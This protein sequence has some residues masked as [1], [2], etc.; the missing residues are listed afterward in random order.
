MSVKT[1]MQTLRII[2][3]EEWAKKYYRKSNSEGTV[4]I[5]RTSLNIFDQFCQTEIGLNGKSRD[6]MIESYQKLFNQDKPDIR[7]ICMSLDKFVGFMGEDHD[8][9]VINGRCNTTFKAKKSKTIKIYFGFIKNYLRICHGIRITNEDIHDYVQFPKH[10]KEPR[11]PISLDT[12]KLLFGKCDPERRA[13]YYVLISSGM[14]IGE[15]LSL[16]KS[17]FHIEERPIRVSLLADDTK[18]L[19]ARET[20]ISNEAWERVKPIF[21]RKNDNEYL[22]HVK[23]FPTILKALKNEE[24]YFISLRK[25][26]GLTERYHNSIRAV[27]NIHSFRA[28]FHTKASQKHGSDYANALDG[29]GAYLKQ[30]YRES[31][32]FREAVKIAITPMITSLSILNYVDMD[33]EVEVLGYGISLIL[34]NVGMYFVAPIIVI[35]RIRK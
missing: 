22:F 3:D 19:E 30:Y 32:V 15:G 28:Y 6:T 9:I 1:T 18:T 2:S 25:K 14:R 29:H 20:Y 10:R 4:H 12:L 26:L 13:L 5:A 17:N 23:K 16:K 24:K 33:S 11:R 21:D 35:M 27:V 8:D 31:P 34:L 7:S